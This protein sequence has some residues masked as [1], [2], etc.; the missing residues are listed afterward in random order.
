[1]AIARPRTIDDASGT[2]RSTSEGRR[3]GDFLVSRGMGR[4]GPGEESR[5][6]RRCGR[7]DRG[8]ADP[9]PDQAKRGKGSVGGNSRGRRSLAGEDI[10]GKKVDDGP[11]PSRRL[12]VRPSDRHA[13]RRGASGA[14]RPLRVFV[15]RAETRGRLTEP[16]DN[17]RSYAKSRETPGA[18]RIRR[19]ART[20][21]PTTVG[22]QPDPVLQQLASGGKARRQRRRPIG[23]G[24]PRRSMTFS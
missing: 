12:R 24:R 1:M 17:G 23:P 15:G 6:H 16:V 3:R 2:D 7:G 19:S 4:V 5:K 14:R 13:H 20:D 18:N 10:C 22:V 8:A 9:R 11:L 21:A